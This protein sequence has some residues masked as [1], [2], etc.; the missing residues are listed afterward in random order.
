MEEIVWTRKIFFCGGEVK[1]GKYLEKEN[2]FM[3]RKRTTEKEKE[4]KIMEKKELSRT[5]GWTKIK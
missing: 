3:R 2:T 1:G 5:G 4:E